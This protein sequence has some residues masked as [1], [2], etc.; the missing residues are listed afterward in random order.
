MR[1]QSS[2]T[3]MVPS[4]SVAVVAAS[5]GLMFSCESNEPAATTYFE[6]SVAPIL[7]NSCVRTGTGAGCH[8]ATEKGNAFGNLDVATFEGV[9]RRRDLLS[10]YGPYGQ[11][12]FLLKSIEPISVEVQSFDGEKTSITTDIRHAGGSILS[13]TATAYLTLRKWIENGATANNTG[14]SGKKIARPDCSKVIPPDQAFDPNAEPT[15]PDYTAFRD[16][17]APMLG[18]TCGATNCHG[19]SSNELYLTCG[20]TNEERRWN[21]FAAQQ[22]L[23]Q[24]PESSELARRPLAPSQGGAYHE[25][26]I[27]FATSSDTRYTDLV[28]WATQHGPPDNGTIDPNFAFFAHRVQPI[29]VKKGCMM[30]QCHSAAQFHDF[31]LRGGSGGSFSLSATRKNYELSVAQLALESENV[32]A[33]RLVRK[34]LFRAEVFASGGGIAHRGGS[35]FEDFSGKSAA[36][37]DC[38]A[39]VDYATIDLNDPKAKAYCVIKEWHKRERAARTLAPFSAIAY[40]KRPANATAGHVRDFDTFVGGAELHVVSVTADATG[41]FTTGAD[42]SINAGCS[43]GGS[44]DIRRPSASWD[45]TKIAFA[46]RATAGDPFAVY[47][48]NADGSSCAKHTEIN[49]GAANGNGLL[50]HNL[51]PV[52][53]PPDAAGNQP[54][55]FASTRGNIA[56]AAYDYTGPQRT[57]SDPSKPNANLYVFTAGQPIRQLTYLLNMEREPFFMSDGRL[58]FTAEKRA[59]DFYQLALRRMNLDGGDYHPLFAQRGTIGFKEATTVVELADK[60]FATIFSDP[61][62]P[63]GGGTLGIFNRSIGIDFTSADAADYV[64]DPTVLDPASKSS[65]EPNFFLHSLALFDPSVSG[66]ANAPTTG[67]FTTPSPL[68]DG[69]L[70][71]SF[72]DATNTSSFGGDYDLYVV[73]T[74]ARTKTKLLGAAGSAEIEAVAVYGRASRGTFVSVQDEPN[75]TTRI[76][77]SKTD[78][79]VHVL[80]ARVLASL[81]FQNTPTGREIEEDINELDLYEDMPPADGVTNYASGGAN[82]ATDAFGQ[83]YVRRRFLGKVPLAS[84]G[85]TIFNVPGGLPLLYKLPETKLSREFGL[86]R[87]QRE[88]IVFA[89]GEITNQSFRRPFFDGLCAACHGAISGRPLDSAVRP[90]LLTEASTTASRGS[91]PYNANVAPAQRGKVEGP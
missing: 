82:V 41:A 77:S 7:Q 83:V 30:Q 32:N 63:H 86:P 9:N 28:D 76:D 14:S 90:D 36:P 15:R 87:L 12:A 40:V 23:S 73:D 64:V 27:V 69:R 4:L 45:G 18:Q 2:I 49:A 31:R 33:S 39:T 62:V 71:V 8:V 52:F 74:I 43:L 47:V 5:T 81:L 51:D 46:A 89:P 26:G 79:T 60:N 65:P 66:K 29:L 55:V 44:P 53:G 16:K 19:S 48:A 85:S 88:S 80:D 17:I 61:G 34:N 38:D 6:R 10:D 57:P 75:A 59:K 56:T 22:Y 54:I 21:Y 13:P 67:L 25:G 68:P 42:A 1:F 50:V 11:N 3:R 37:D 35:L 78:A 24:T 58:V 20:S 84:D 70:L 72:G 91:S